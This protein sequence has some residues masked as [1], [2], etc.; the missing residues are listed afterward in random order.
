MTDAAIDSVPNG[1]A[2][3]R[4]HGPVTAATNKPRRRKHKKNAVDAENHRRRPIFARAVLVGR[5]A[6]ERD[7]RIGYF[8]SAVLIS[9][10]I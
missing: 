1:G 6:R 9:A 8:W 7:G 2:V 10:I 5:G 3:V 4:V